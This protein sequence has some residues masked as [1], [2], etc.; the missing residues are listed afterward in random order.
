MSDAAF[1]VWNNL[2]AFGIGD[3]GDSSHSCCVS[4]SRARILAIESVIPDNRFL[5][6]GN[7]RSEMGHQGNK[8]FKRLFFREEAQYCWARELSN[9]GVLGL[10]LELGT[11]RALR[12]P[13]EIFQ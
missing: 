13:P 11:L 9:M 2:R 3:I 6:P 10:D 1:P 8:D 7:A 12:R 5:V 4:P